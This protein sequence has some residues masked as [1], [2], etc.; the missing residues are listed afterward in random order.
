M[1]W[2]IEFL[3][4]AAWVI[5]LRTPAQQ[6]GLAEAEAVHPAGASTSIAERAAEGQ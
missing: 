5:R 3:V 4:V 6:M 1:D 2:L